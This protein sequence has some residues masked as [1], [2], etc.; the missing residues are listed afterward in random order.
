MQKPIQKPGE[1]RRNRRGTTLVETVISLLAFILVVLGMLDLGIGVMR[2]NTVSEAA[3]IG[4]RMAIVHGSKAPT[5]ASFGGPWDGANDAA[6]IKAR[7][8]PLLQAEG[9]ALTDIAV[10]VAHTDGPDTG[11]ATTND[12]GDLVTVTVTVPYRPVLSYFFGSTT[13]TLTGRSRMAI[14]H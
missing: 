4:A 14:A 3:R 10:T 7:I 8:A 1:R 11:T 9:V 2:S 5:A 13:Q 6:A 12:P